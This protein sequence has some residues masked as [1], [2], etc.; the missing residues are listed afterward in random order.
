MVVTKVIENPK[1]RYCGQ[2]MIL[3]QEVP[4]IND[5]WYFRCYCGSRA[6]LAHSVPDAWVAAVDWPMQKPLTFE[7]VKA[8]PK[9]C[10]VIL[11]DLS[12]MSIRPVIVSDAND[13]SVTIRNDYGI[14]S[15]RYGVN[16]RFWL[17][18]TFRNPSDKE[19]EAAPWGKHESNP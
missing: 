9:P 1:C 8:L 6:P 17:C 13:V 12:N 11:E 16:V 14:W 4:G 18:G 3:D 7:E 10:V 5:N 19:R 15:D 2:P